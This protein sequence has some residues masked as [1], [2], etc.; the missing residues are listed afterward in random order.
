[1][2]TE[3]IL[4]VDMD[5][6]FVEVERLTDPG[7]RS[8]PVA[9]G[10][11]GNRG[12]IASASYEARAVGVRSAQ[13]TISALR[14]CPQLTVIHP[15]HHRYSLVSEQ[16]FEI[17]RSF[18]PDVEGLSLDEAFLD[19]SGLKRHYPTPMDVAEGI[20]AEIRERIGLPASVGVAATK[21]MAKLASASAKPDG[22]LHVPRSAQLDFLHALP[23]EALWGVGPATLAGLERLGVATIGE[24][25]EL[26][27]RTVVSA[28][29]AANGRHL[30]ALA[31]GIDD[32]P[33]QPDLEAK[34]VSVEETYESDLVGRAVIETALLAHAQRLSG[35][36]R[37]TGLAA[38]TVTVKVRYEDFTTIT[39]SLTG[40]PID[41]PRDLYGCGIGLLEDVD[42]DRPVRL[43]G[44]G[45][46]KLEVGDEPRQLSLDGS[47]QWQKLADAVSGVRERFG[48]RSVEPA[49]LV[50]SP[51]PDRDQSQ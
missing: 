51:A 1:M 4:H 32:R 40:E 31:N 44:L 43:L 19:V 16:V 24:L 6:F 41:S 34:S 28:L 8:R 25:A 17:F 45:G 26:P 10:G 48:E 22:C 18:T 38:R 20:R 30:L 14:L 35:R 49:R 9:V 37:R 23:V 27:E 50:P 15:D 46:S 21:F 36:L 33:V 5:A 11:T 3:P 29:G 7:L 47:E 12:V 39:R 13:P 42:L 2:W